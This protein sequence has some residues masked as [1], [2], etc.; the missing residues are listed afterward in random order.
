M[1]LGTWVIA[2]DPTVPAAGL[3]RSTPGTIPLRAREV[4]RAL[5]VLLSLLP[6]LASADGPANL[7]LFS[8]TKSE[9]K[10]QVVYAL[11]VDAACR[12]V[13]DAPVHAYW[14]MLEKG[15]SSTEPLLAYEQLAYGMESQECELLADGTRLVRVRLRA[16]PERTIVIRAS[17]TDAAC[18]ATATATIASASASLDNVYA[19]VRPAVWDRIRSRCS[20]RALA[21]GAA[22]RE[23]L[24]H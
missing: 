14:R 1:S 12:P 20:G 3:A 19:L 2:R 10:N 11:Q 4:K 18:T 23:T 5:A 16:L 6:S 24:Q 22:V 8:I 13:G 7:S 9:N 21:S 17:R 15:P